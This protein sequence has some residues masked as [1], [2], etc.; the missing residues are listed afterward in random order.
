MLEVSFTLKD[1]YM[2]N[3]I[4]KSSAKRQIGMVMWYQTLVI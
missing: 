2:L 1:N 3:C 4:V